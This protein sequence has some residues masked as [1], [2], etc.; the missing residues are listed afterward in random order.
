MICNNLLF[1]IAFLCT[2]SLSEQ[3]NVQTNTLCSKDCLERCCDITTNGLIDNLTLTYD[4]NQLRKVTD[5]AGSP[6]YT[7]VMDFRDGVDISAEYLYDSNGN[8]TC[9]LN[10]GITS[11][12]YNLLNLPS[13]ITFSRG[14]T[15]QYLYD[16]EGRKL[17]VT[18]SPPPLSSSGQT[19]TDYCDNVIYKDGALERILTDEGYIT[20]SASGIPTYHYFLRDHLGSVN[21]VLDSNRTVEETTHYYP[22]GTTFPQTS[23]Q[24]YKFCGKELDRVH[25]LDW[26]DSQARMYDP[27]LARWH[28]QDSKAEDYYNWSP[29][30]YC[31]GNPVMYVDPDG[32]DTLNITYTNNKW[33][34]STPFI[35][36]GD[37]VFNVTI[38]GESSSYTFSEKEY[39]NRVNMLNLEIGED[40][41]SYTL[42]VYH[43][44]GVKEGGTGYYV[45]PGGLS[46]IK[47]G[48]GR[49]IPDGVYPITTPSGGE[50]WRKPGVGGIASKRGIRFHYGGSNPRAWTQGCFVLSTS[51]SYSGNSIR[52]DPNVSIEASRSFDK[53]LGGASHYSYS[54]GKKHRE[55]TRF[56]NPISRYLILKSVY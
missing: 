36:E 52:Y 28:T 2:T 53:S 46:S 3:E 18:H 32:C 13:Q 51:Y 49:R 23:V 45:T 14:S 26:Y 48:S 21:V 25:G 10:R 22:Y 56:T 8:A 27:V 35:V 41:N 16:A 24:P 31:K 44:S 1:T 47:E 15:I 34:I 29:Y 20:L 4:G 39:G 40:K 33:N 54:L 7:G 5:A 30:V 6:T 37:D 17:N 43:V 55:G 19:T 12:T 50:M 42:G 38:N 11:I 9:D